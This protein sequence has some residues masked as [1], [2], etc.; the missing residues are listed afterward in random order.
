MP[1]LTNMTFRKLPFESFDGKKYDGYI[2]SF[3]PVLWCIKD[4]KIGYISLQFSYPSL[5]NHERKLLRELEDAF[6]N[7]AIPEMFADAFK[8]DV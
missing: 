6:L 8:G 3:T 5:T 7:N 1:P 2:M 4:G